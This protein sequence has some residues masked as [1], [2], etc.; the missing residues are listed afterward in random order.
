M[1]SDHAPRFAGLPPTLLTGLTGA[2]AFGMR[3]DA[4][5]VT[6]APSDLRTVCWTHR[7]VNSLTVAQKHQAPP[8]RALAAAVVVPVLTLRLPSFLF[9]LCFL[10]R[11]RCTGVLRVAAGGRGPGFNP[12]P[13]RRCAGSRCGG[14][15]VWPV[16]RPSS[17][18]GPPRR[19]ALGARR[20]RR[21]TRRPTPSSPAT[22]SSRGEVPTLNKSPDLTSRST[23]HR[24][25]HY[26]VLIYT[27]VSSY[28]RAHQQG[29]GGGGAGGGAG[30]GGDAWVVRAVGEC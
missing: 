27:Y 8:P 15:R 1:A 24:F 25:Y 6:A 2:L 29:G 22:A 16:P 17:G 12:S 13:N 5:A 9:H 4:A 20:L 19:A 30:G 23:P 7:S 3:H 18:C 10:C 28:P 21:G 26:H 14:S 11:G